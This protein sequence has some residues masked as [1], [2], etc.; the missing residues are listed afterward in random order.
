MNEHVSQ[1]MHL[2]KSKKHSHVHDFLRETCALICMRRQ[3]ERTD[4]RRYIVP[5]AKT[6]VDEPKANDGEVCSPRNALSLK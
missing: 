2:L 1:S 4:I 6:G 5:R 3:K